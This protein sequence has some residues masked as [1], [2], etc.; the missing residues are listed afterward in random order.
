MAYAIDTPLNTSGS[1]V[2]QS[3]ANDGEITWSWSA[4]DGAT[5]Y[6]VTVDGIYAGETNDLSF[7]SGNLWVGEHSM[8]VDAID[9]NGNS[10]VQSATIKVNVTQASSDR[11]TYAGAPPPSQG[12]E[13]AAS[14]ESQIDP[15]SYDYPEVYQHSGYELVFSDEF[16]GTAL[17]PFRWSS[18]LR[19]DGE[20]NG[21]R[22]EYRVINGEDQFY[23]NV[24]SE[25]QEHQESIVPVYNPFQFD[26]STLSIRAVKNP[27]QTSTKKLTYG[28]LKQISSQQTFLSGAI[29]THEKFSQKFGYFEARIKIPSANGT[30]PAFWL[31][32][33]KRVAE[34]T[35]RTEIDIMENLGHAPWYIY[36]SFHYFKNVTSSHFGD[37][38][39]IK[40]QPS[41]QVYTGLDYSEDF[42]V[43]AVKWAPGRITWFI[44]GE[45][46]SEVA[47]NEANFEELYVIL[48]LAMG[49]NWTNFPNNAGGLGRRSNNRF[50]SPNDLV[51]FNNPALV[52]DYVRF[53]KAK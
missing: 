7:T 50:P 10:S 34:G 25:D 37:A 30:F 3:Y 8:T 1:E 19:W 35:Q 46:V 49:G 11:N 17:N 18:Q 20:F 15:T 14:V 12:D 36:N 27:L 22:Y 44:D 6:Q 26:G 53:Y 42:H 48:N 4:V 24:L 21:E 38:N 5:S 32:H 39:F 2:A 40:P 28:S 9:A 41:G 43:Y 52:I 31:L 23:V 33:E 16:N 13:N 45:Q 29:S 47:N 51:E